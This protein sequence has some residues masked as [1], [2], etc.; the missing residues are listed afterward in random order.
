MRRVLA[1][2]AASALLAAVP[3][4]AGAARML[5][6]QGYTSQGHEISFKRSKAGVLSMKIAVRA[7]CF[8]DQGQSAGDYDF[9]LRA[10][11]SVADPVKRGKFMVRLAGE[12]KTP[13]AT[14][15]GTIN[16]RGVARGTI[17]AVGR[18][19]NPSDIG[20]CR[21]GAVRWTAGP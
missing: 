17:A 11:D 14:I 21:S 6:Y 12:A 13:D 16:S 4:A 8:T 19:T 10:V 7:S 9:T 5:S 1:V 2:A 15:K 20:T 3:P 18:V